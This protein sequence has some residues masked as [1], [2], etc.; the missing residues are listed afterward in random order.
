MIRVFEAA[1]LPRVEA[2][3]RELSATSLYQR[4]FVGTPAI[5]T[6]LL[7]QL[8]RLDHEQQ[9][10]VVALVGTRV[11]GLAQYARAGGSPRAELAVLVADSWQRMGVGRALVTRLADL[12]LARGIN[13]FDAAVLPDNDPARLGIA[14]LWPGA[15]GTADED[16]LNY[17]LPLTRPLAP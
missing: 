4:F 9:E 13:V 15:L 17:R 8:A 12:A 2:M 7:R 5:P 1:D 10:A 3:S 14:H 16:S 6:A 11:V